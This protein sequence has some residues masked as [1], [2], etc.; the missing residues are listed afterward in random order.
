[1]DKEIMDLLIKEGDLSKLF[2]ELFKYSL[3]KD[4]KPVFSIG[5]YR[6]GKSPFYKVLK[7]I[8]KKD[9]LEPIENLFDW[10]DIIKDNKEV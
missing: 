9:E 1:M 8:D 10:Q 6:N 2:N 7:D 5:G 4:I 3:N